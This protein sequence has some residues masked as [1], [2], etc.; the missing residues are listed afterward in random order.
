MEYRCE[1]TSVAGFVQQL[2]SCYLPHGY[3]FYVSGQIP[4]HKNGG[5]VDDKLTGKY[6]VGLS[7]QSRARRKRVGIANIHYLRHDRFF[8]LLAT[9]GHHPF[10]DDEAGNIRDARRVSIKFAGYSI[11]VRRLQ[12]KGIARRPGRS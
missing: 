9:H 8:V 1:A 7:R 11:G 4:E 10:Y 3:W 2:A 5:R 6:D 12:E